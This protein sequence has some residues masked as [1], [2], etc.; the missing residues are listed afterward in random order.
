M[1]VD[2]GTGTGMFI[3]ISYSLFAN[4]VNRFSVHVVAVGVKVV[5]SEGVTDAMLRK[6]AAT[7]VV[8]DILPVR[9]IFGEPY[10]KT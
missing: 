5:V 7:D 9:D 4:I 8:E 10:P 6:L 1:N 3:H 2:P